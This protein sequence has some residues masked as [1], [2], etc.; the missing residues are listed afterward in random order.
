MVEPGGAPSLLEIL[1]RYDWHE[2]AACRDEP[3]ERTFFPEPQSGSKTKRDSL[4]SPSVLLPVL[5]CLGCPA[6]REC[7]EEA[8]RPVSF[9]H[10]TRERIAPGNVERKWRER[11]GTR[12]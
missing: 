1:E 12:R 2:R 4:A 6:R 5:I 7:L 11:E 8:L 3:D 9:Q 10:G